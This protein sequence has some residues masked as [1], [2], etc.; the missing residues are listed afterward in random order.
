MSKKTWDTLTPKQQKAA[1]A[2]GAESSENMKM[3]WTE[4]EIQALAKAKKEGVVVL[5]K[6]QIGINGIESFAVKLYTKYVTNAQDL[7]AVLSI[8]RDK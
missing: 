5:E 1:K 4:S 2:A 3:L 6:S 8:M 7:E